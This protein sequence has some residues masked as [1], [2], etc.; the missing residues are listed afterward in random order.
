VAEER[1]CL[2]TRLVDLETRARDLREREV[3]FQEKEAKVEGLVAEKSTGIKW[4][5]KWVGEANSSL[6]TLRLSPIQVVEAPPSFGAVLLS[7]PIY[8]N[9]N[10]A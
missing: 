4:V 3:A 7:H 9:I 8:K 6:N 5:V 1:A 10:R 2:A